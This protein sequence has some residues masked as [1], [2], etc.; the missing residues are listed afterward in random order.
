MAER[1]VRVGGV[2]TVPDPVMLA[3][4][5]PPDPLWGGVAL[6]LGILVMFGLS[7]WREYDARRANI[8]LMEATRAAART[9]S[10]ALIQRPATAPAHCPYCKDELD[11]T[12]DG[13]V[14]CSACETTQH[15]TCWRENGGCSTHACD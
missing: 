12:A 4:F 3:S 8:E 10:E 15:A 11:T 2:L 14:R 7:A 6:A 5:N 13:I 9:S 1:L